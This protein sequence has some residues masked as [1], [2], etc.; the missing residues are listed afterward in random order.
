MAV[1][2]IKNIDTQTKAGWPANIDGID[3]TDDDLLV[4]TIHA[5][6]GVINAKWDAGGTLRNGTPDGNLDVTESE[7]A[8]VVDTASR[9]RT[10]FP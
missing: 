9:L 1:L 7:V 4:G 10:L 2:L 6:A 8:D 3:P 5:P